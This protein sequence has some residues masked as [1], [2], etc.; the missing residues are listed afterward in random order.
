MRQLFQNLITNT[1]KFKAEFD[2]FDLKAK[3]AI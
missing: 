3:V 2:A 1:L